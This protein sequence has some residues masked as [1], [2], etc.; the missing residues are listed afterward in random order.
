VKLGLSGRRKKILQGTSWRSVA[1]LIL[2]PKNG[3]EF[4]MRS[5]RSQ[6]FMRRIFVP[7]EPGVEL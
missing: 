6:R 4:F 5:L 7:S 2:A 1:P 3:S